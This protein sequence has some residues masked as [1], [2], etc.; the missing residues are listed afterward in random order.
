MYTLSATETLI[1][2]KS[3]L[4]IGTLQRTKLSMKIVRVLIIVFLF[5]IG[6]TLTMS[7]K[8]MNI[9]IVFCTV[10]VIIRYVGLN[11]PCAV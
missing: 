4:L 1:A 11:G 8:V 7:V 3:K 6:M 2:K 10:N 9:F 5:C